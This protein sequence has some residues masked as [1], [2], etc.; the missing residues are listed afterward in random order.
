MASLL[1][2]TQAFGSPGIPPRWTSAR[3]QAIGTAYSSASRVWFTLWQGILTEIY[4]PTVDHPQTRDWQLL[5]ADGADLF[6]EEKRDFQSEVVSLTR[7]SLGFKVLQRQVDGQYSLE[8]TIIADPH[9]P[10][11]LQNISLK[12]PPSLRQKLN[13]YTLCAPHLGVGGD[14]NNAYVCVANGRKLLVANKK[15]TWMAIG[16]T[17][18][19]KKASTGFVGK[20]DGWTD[21]NDNSSMDWQFDCAL[22]GNV[23]LTGMLDLSQTDEFVLAMAFGHGF[24]NAVA[25]LLQS[26]AF[27]F[28]SHAQRFCE[29]WAR[30]DKK[31]SRLHQ[32]SLDGGALYESSY[33]ILLAHEDK[34]NP[35]AFIAS[36]SIPWGDSKGDDDLGGYHLV[37]PRDMVNTATGLL[38]A[39]NTDSPLRALMFLCA[40]QKA[41]GGFYQN[42]WI[43]G[44]PYWKGVQL[45]E[46]SFPIMLAWRLKRHNGL[47]NFDP[48]PM[49]KAAVGYLMLNG[50]ITQQERWEEV[51]GFSP[52]T[53]AANIAAL[54]CAASFARLDNDE[55]LATFIQDYADYLKCHLEDWTVT[56]SGELLPGVPQHFVRINPAKKMQDLSDPDSAYVFIANRDPAEQ[57]TFP[58]RNV[59]DGGFLELV[60]YGIYAADDPLIK[61]S[62][63]VIDAVLK[64]ETPNGPC[65]RRYNYDGYGQKDDGSPFDGTGVGR[66]WPLLTGERGHYELAAGRDPQP[67]IK[68]MENFVG[69]CASTLPEQ[70]WDAEDIPEAHLQKG[71]TTGAAK[72][73]AWAHAE[74]IKLLRSAAEGR[75]F[76]L[77]PEVEER[78]I[79]S[80]QTCKLIEIWHHGWQPQK[81]H[82][83]YTLRVMAARPF[84]LSLSVDG[85]QGA[86]RLAS[87]ETAIS[88]HY[89]DVPL[90]MGRSKSVSFNFIFA[91]DGPQDETTYKITVE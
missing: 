9:Y 81:V 38:A 33:K 90:T 5:F 28:E 60:R 42:F 15:N 52:S 29:Q 66:L 18:P 8:K 57:N 51:S 19:F 22:D 65:W 44:E 70:I 7:D 34:L 88:V 47:K 72:P 63:A 67:Y 4:Y 3:K 25:V 12:V 13:V 48:Y 89:V 59:V 1:T 31:D 58:A 68:A 16:A 55:Q 73:L 76:D 24:H 78:Y 46:V 45:D 54:T 79:K 41:D 71:E 40:A 77:I 36:L 11:I 84:G 91:D 32:P 21:L 14:G 75:V 20:S 23:A 62:V 56:T 10:C 82:P 61:N 35:G 17:V 53:L 80:P 39:G 69:K 27:P 6:H 30:A 49:V 85:G 74:Y 26:L 64:G 87:K 37:W 86:S 2:R 83:N 43:S 50:P